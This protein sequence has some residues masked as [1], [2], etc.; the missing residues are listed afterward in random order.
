MRATFLSAQGRK[1]GKGARRWHKGVL[2][3]TPCHLATFL[4]PWGLFCHPTASVTGKGGRRWHALRATFPGGIILHLWTA[5]SP[6]RLSFSC[7][8]SRGSLAP[9]ERQVFAPLLC[10]SPAWQSD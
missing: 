2:Y 8:R 9:Q 4:P 1:A 3:S 6:V 7:V 10:R 5:L